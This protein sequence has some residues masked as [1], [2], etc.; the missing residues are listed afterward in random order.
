MSE[1]KKISCDELFAHYKIFK[2]SHIE[3]VNHS[4]IPT[5]TQ[6]PSS[7]ERQESMTCENMSRSYRGSVKFWC[8]GDWN[9]TPVSYA[10]EYGLDICS[11]EKE[12]SLFYDLS[13]DSSYAYKTKYV[14]R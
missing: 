6:S 11:A 5:Y 10:S 8:K 14:I 1:V 9:K 13:G 7:R 4:Y 2:N 12:E 3:C